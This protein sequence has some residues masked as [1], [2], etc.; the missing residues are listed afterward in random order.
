MRFPCQEDLISDWSLMHSSAATLMAD[1]QGSIPRCTSNLIGDSARSRLKLAKLLKTIDNSLERHILAW[2]KET[3]SNP[4]LCNVRT[5]FI[6]FPDQVI[7]AWGPDASR[8]M[9]RNCSA[10]LV[11]PQGE[12]HA[13]TCSHRRG[14]AVTSWQSL[15]HHQTLR[16]VIC[17]C[18]L[19]NCPDS[20]RLSSRPRGS[21][22]E[23]PF[24][25][26][27]PWFWTAFHYVM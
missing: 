14:R 7:L 15:G 12:P 1:S 26:F 16:G 10:Y 9:E 17:A 6:Y 19:I 11:P 3:K 20:R 27:P 18:P 21:S 22:R 24:S 2:G 23:F 13:R 8:H 4:I 25:P 5:M